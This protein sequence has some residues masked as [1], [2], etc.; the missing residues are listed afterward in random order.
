[1]SIC[2]CTVY[3]SSTGRSRSRKGL[4]DID[5][6]NSLGEGIDVAIQQGLE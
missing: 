1:M 5:E 3:R 4:S 2:S 6:Q